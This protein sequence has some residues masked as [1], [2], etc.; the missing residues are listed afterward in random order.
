M[1]LQ[2]YLIIFRALDMV[3][4][5]AIEFL[6]DGELVCVL[7]VN[8]YYDY[9]FCLDLKPMNGGQMGFSC[10][11]VKKFA[12]GECSNLL[13]VSSPFALISVIALLAVLIVV[14]TS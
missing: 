1:V 10:I 2:E 14:V 12:V 5:A 11:S 4:Y 6:F 9:S 13:L 7:G 3:E 8:M